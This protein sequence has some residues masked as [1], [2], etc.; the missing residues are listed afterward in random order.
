MRLAAAE[1]RD[2]HARCARGARAGV[3]HLRGAPV[4]RAAAPARAAARVGHGVAARLR[5]APAPAAVRAGDRLLDGLARRAAPVAAPALHVGVLVQAV[6]RLH[7]LNAALGPGAHARQVQHRMAPG[8]RP[9]G[10]LAQDGV[11]AD[12]TIVVV[13]GELGGQ[14]GT[15]VRVLGH[16]CR[17]LRRRRWRRIGRGRELG[18]ERGRGAPRWL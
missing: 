15:Q 11:V 12:R 14:A 4:P 9:D 7:L 17:S 16:R 5:D 1:A 2:A 3:A 8:T 6:L 18:A 13:A 10:L